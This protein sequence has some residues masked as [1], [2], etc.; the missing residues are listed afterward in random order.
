MELHDARQIALNLM[1]KH[2]L[3]GWA[4][5]FDNA[6]RRFGACHF[7]TKRITLSIYL[8]ALNEAAKVT[9]VILHEIA[10]ALVGYKHGHNAVWKA[11]AI[12]IGCNGMRCYS[13]ENTVTP[14][15]RYIGTCPNGHTHKRHKRP[16]KVSSCAKCCPVYNS[17]YTI[18]YILN[19]KFGK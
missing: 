17:N 13:S 10:H 14:E 1:S 4:F 16:T 9:D 2:G 12:E 3:T 18:T 6:K 11:K 19:P 7:R 15:S 5:D 8:V